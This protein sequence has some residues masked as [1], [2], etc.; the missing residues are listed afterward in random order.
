MPIYEYKCN[1]CGC[2]FEELVFSTDCTDGFCCPSCGDGDT[3]RVMSCFSCGSSSGAGDM[4]S[5]L[6]SACS[7]PSGKFT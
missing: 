7:S 1:K 2:V 6:S 3:G 5:G 4:S